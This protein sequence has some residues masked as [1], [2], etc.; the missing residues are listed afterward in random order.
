[1]LNPP[2]PGKKV[3]V[4]DIVR[5]F[6][7]SCQVLRSCPCVSPGQPAA[8]RCLPE[9]C[10]IQ[11]L[12]SGT[13]AQRSMHCLVGFR[14]AALAAAFLVLRHVLRLLQSR[15]VMDESSAVPRRPQ[16]YT[17][18]DLGSSAERPHELARP[19]LHEFMAAVYP[20]YVRASHYL[21]PL[22]TG[23]SVCTRT[24]KT[25]AACCTATHCSLC[26]LSAINTTEPAGL[27]VTMI[28][29]HCTGHHHLV[30]H[31]NEVGRGAHFDDTNLRCCRIGRQVLMWPAPLPASI[32]V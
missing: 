18:F 15:Q 22:W 25:S 23:M 14:C 6:N 21:L 13:T 1:M 7:L 8:T 26:S 16:D 3:V 28:S 10:H 2:R 24:Y 30:S 31:V 27:A 20:H 9:A 4:L 32:A 11:C 12:Q 17:I 5:S 19:H 29:S